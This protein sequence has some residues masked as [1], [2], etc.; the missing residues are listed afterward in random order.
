M[1]GSLAAAFNH[2][3]RANVALGW[4]ASMFVARLGWQAGTLRSLSENIML[5]IVVAPIVCIRLDGM[6][7][8]LVTAIHRTPLSDLIT[9]T[10]CTK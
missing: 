1:V 2:C 6:I 7:G 10:S 9:A 5:A 8:S 3:C 4:R